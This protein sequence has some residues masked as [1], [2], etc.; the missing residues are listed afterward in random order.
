MHSGRMNRALAGSLAAL[1]SAAVLAGCSDSGDKDAN[2]DPSTPAS[3]SASGSGSGSPSASA[4][5]TPYLPVPEGVEL[6]PEGTKLAVGDSAVVA[7]EPRQKVVGVLDIKVTKLVRTTFKES[8]EGWKLDGAT[9]KA[10]PYFVHATIKNIGQSNLGTLRP[11]LRGIPLYIV[12]GTNTLIEPSTFASSFKPCPSTPLPDTFA[13]GKKVKAC[14]VY[15]S[16]DHGRLVA[17]SFRPVED[18][19]P[20]V[21]TGDIEKVGEPKRGKGKN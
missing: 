20:I 1:L 18:F 13:P 21:W 15:L 14:L 19:T 9:K 17:V 6:T 4:S 11:E 7:Y 12:D 16:P 8:F 10:T 3:S 5:E 2:T